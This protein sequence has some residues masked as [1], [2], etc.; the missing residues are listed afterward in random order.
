MRKQKG[1]RMLSVESG[2]FWYQ[3]L[4]GGG[5]NFVVRSAPAKSLHSVGKILAINPV[6]E[7]TKPAEK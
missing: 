5:K 3:S 6:V 2:V 1:T 4:L 7:G